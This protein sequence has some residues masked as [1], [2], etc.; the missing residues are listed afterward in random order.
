MIG[1]E[2]R[3]SV[4]NISMLSMGRNLR[5]SNQVQDVARAWH[6]V[7]YKF[8]EPESFTAGKEDLQADCNW[9]YYRYVTR[10]EFL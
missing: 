4:T 8:M 9:K 7:E 3:K 2:N 10:V 1:R 6:G 5:A